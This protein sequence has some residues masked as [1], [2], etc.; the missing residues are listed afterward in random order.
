ME[1]KR[2]ELGLLQVG[3]ILL[4]V[5]TAAIHFSLV[6]PSVLFILN[7]FGYLTLLATLYLPI[8]Q[9]TGYRHLLRWALMGYTVL[10][11]VLWVIMGS[12]LPIAYVNKAVEIVLIVLLGVESRQNT[13]QHA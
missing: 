2:V 8:P 9:L 11:V 4:T 5:S 7:G 10:T 13:S 12:R 3:I 6:F 1:R